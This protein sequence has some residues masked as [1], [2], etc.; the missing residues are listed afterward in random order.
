M[1]A[2]G[3]F[4]FTISGVYLVDY[5]LCI[6]NYHI[7]QNIFSMIDIMYYIRRYFITQDSYTLYISDK[8]HNAIY[9][10]IIRILFFLHGIRLGFNSQ[11]LPL[12][13]IMPSSGRSILTPPRAAPLFHRGSYRSSSFRR[14]CVIKQPINQTHYR[15]SVYPHPNLVTINPPR[16]VLPSDWPSVVLHIVHATVS[17][18]GS[19]RTQGHR[20]T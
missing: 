3:K 10:I 13:L 7:C 4:S 14:S 11:S 2:V 15:D 20:P 6:I 12:P 8:S 1:D 19:L 5:I 18:P 9:H 16:H 17:E